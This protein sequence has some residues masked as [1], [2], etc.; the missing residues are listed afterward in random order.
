MLEA[1]KVTVKYNAMQD[2]LLFAAELKNGQVVSLWMTSRLVLPMVKWIAT[3]VDASVSSPNRL[4]E[5]VLQNWHQEAAALS[6][7]KVTRVKVKRDDSNVLVQSVDISIKDN[8][9]VLVFK[10]PDFASGIMFSLSSAAMRQFLQIIYA[11]LNN[12]NWCKEVWPMW[13][14]KAKTTDMDKSRVIN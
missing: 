14:T 3:K 4:T 2:R 12:V 10:W 6:T 1:L 7:P 13:I 8:N 5:N 11:Q 9:F